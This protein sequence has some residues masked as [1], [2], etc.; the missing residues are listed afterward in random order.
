MRYLPLA[1]AAIV[2]AV[3]L[4]GQ[5]PYQKWLDEDVVYI[6]TDTE[7]QTFQQ[8]SSDAEREEFIRQFW[9]RRSPI[10]GQAENPFKEEHYRR[11]GYANERF[12][13]G[14]PGWKTDRGRI[15]IVFGPPDEIESHPS[16]GRFQRPPEQG[17]DEI[18]TW[19]FEQW[20][21]RQPN[22]SGAMIFEFVDPTLTGEYR[23]AH[24]AT[25]KEARLGVVVGPAGTVTISIPIS[26]GAPITI[27]GRITRPT[28]RVV[29]V[30]EETAHGPAYRKV[31]SLPPGSYILT[32]VVKDAAGKAIQQELPFAI[33]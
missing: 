12:G 1:L 15:Y 30:F 7:R 16:G 4:P 28:R 10:P 31:I 22:G 18:S 20:V 25:E 24:D 33:K 13:T 32:T 3:V 19:P 11:I 27:Y 26:P 2:F 29:N 6:I 9:A 21:Y 5:S 23:L 8:L 17:G 14:I